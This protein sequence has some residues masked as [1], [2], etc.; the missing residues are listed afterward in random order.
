[1]VCSLLFHDLQDLHGADLSADTAGDTLGG[2]AVGRHDHDLHRANLN[3]LAAGGAQLL[4]DHIHA[5]LGILGDGTSFTN[6]GTLTALNA[7][8]GLGTAA[9]GNDLD[10]GQVRI[11]F[12]I[13]RVGTGTDTLQTSHALGALLNHKLLHI[14]K[15]PLFFFISILLYRMPPKIAMGKIDFRFLFQ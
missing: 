3:T 9:L 7:G 14:K 5:G 13:K 11:E 12:L 8:H 15:N 2:G 6:L 1:M 10:A 4:V